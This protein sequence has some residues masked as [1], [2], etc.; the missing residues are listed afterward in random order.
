MLLKADVDTTARIGWWQWRETE[1]EEFAVDHG[2]QRAARAKLVLNGSPES[3]AILSEASSGVEAETAPLS[4]NGLEGVAMGL[5]GRLSRVKRLVGVVT[6]NAIGDV[7]G[8]EIDDS[9]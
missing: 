8:D 9:V 7:T 1:T 2:E 6:R 5:K 3:W 4:G